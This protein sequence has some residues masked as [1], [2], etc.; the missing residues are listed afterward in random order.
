M[1]MA[2]VKYSVTPNMQIHE[3]LA[4][5]YESGELADFTV[6]VGDT[7]FNVSK[8]ILAAQS[9]Y[10]HSM[11]LG[12][13]KEATATNVTLVDE[14]PTAISDMLKFLYTGVYKPTIPSTPEA[15]IATTAL[16]TTTDSGDNTEANKAAI[17]A[18]MT[19][20]IVGDKFFIPALRYASKKAFS[21]AVDKL[22]DHAVLL[23]LLEEVY[24]SVPDLRTAAAK[25][26]VR[27]LEP[28]LL[29]ER[30]KKMMV[31]VDGLAVDIC[32]A[33]L[34]YDTHARTSLSNAS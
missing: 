28:L 30:F 7:Q 9:G 16:A 15:Q 33:V 25:C 13:W 20:Y 17:V 8:I 26:M 32:G 3:G 12:K 22:R 19:Q 24:A 10:F 29:D 2:R 5:I 11:F 21:S 34:R 1:E 14:D 6:I 27:H 23:D 31:E 18:H 4:T